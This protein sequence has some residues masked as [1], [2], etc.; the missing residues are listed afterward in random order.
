M[1]C[2]INYKGNIYSK[3]EFL[4]HMRENP[5]EFVPLVD[6]SM[7][8][9]INTTK[10]TP[11]QEKLEDEFS[12]DLVN[13]F[14]GV[15]ASAPVEVT[16]FIQNKHGFTPGTKEFSFM[17]RRE[18]L[19][20][21][22]SKEQTPFNNFVKRGI[23]SAVGTQRFEDL[24]TFERAMYDAVT[25]TVNILNKVPNHNPETQTV[26][27][28]SNGNYEVVENTDLLNKIRGTKGNEYLAID[29]KL[30]DYIIETF[31]ASSAVNADLILSPADK[32]DAK[33]KLLG[34]LSKLGIS[35]TSLDNYIKNY[36]SVNGV[37]PSVE[38]LADIT[39]K[40]VA[41]S[42]TGSTLEN[43][44]E[45]VSH[46]LV[47]AYQNQ[48][49]IDSVLP[50]V[51]TTDEWAQHS[52]HYTELYSQQGLVGEQLQNKVRREVLGKVIAQSVAQQVVE[53]TVYER[54]LGI[55]NNFINR[56]KA[57]FSPSMNTQLTDLVDRISQGAFEEAKFNNTFSQDALDS[58]AFDI[59]YSAKASTVTTNLQNALYAMEKQME[60][61]RNEGTGRSVKMRINTLAQ[62]IQNGD[63]LQG[64]STYLDMT[65]SLLVDVKRKVNVAK[66]LEKKGQLKG[67]ILLGPQ[68]ASAHL[69]MTEGKAQLNSLRAELLKVDPATSSESQK[70]AIS[71]MV[72]KLDAFNRDIDT[73]GGEMKRLTLQKGEEL[74]ETLLE[75]QQL[76][77]TDKDWFR[78][79]L[80]EKIHDVSML[81]F[82][83]GNMMN[84]SN[85]ILLMVSKLINKMHSRV[86]SRD[87]KF[88][89]T[90]Y[91][92][93]ESL[94][95]LDKMDQLIQ[96]DKN[97]NKTN[98]FESV[99][100]HQTFEND[101][102]AEKVKLYNEALLQDPVFAEMK[103][104]TKEH[105][106]GREDYP[107]IYEFEDSVRESYEKQLDQWMEDN[108]EPP[109]NASFKKMREDMFDAIS[110]GITLATG[111]V[112]NT[113]P[114]EAKQ[115]MADW[116]RR[117]REIKEPY[118][119]DGVVD[120]SAMSDTDR[121]ELESIKKERKMAAAII[122]ASTLSEKTGTELEI[123]LA[124][125]A[126]NV[127]YSSSKASTR[128]I[129]DVFIDTLNNYSSN[130]N[131][132]AGNTQALDFFFKNSG[133]S[134]NENFWND[135]ASNSESITEKIDNFIADN[136][137]ISEEAEMRDVANKL[138][139]ALKTRSSFL[140]QYSNPL[141]PAEV[142]VNSMSGDML[143][144]FRD[145]ESD[146]E[147][148]QQFLN[149]KL[150]ANSAVRVLEVESTA[151]EA[152]EEALANARLLR[153]KMSEVEFA[154]EHMTPGNKS[155]VILFQ[156]QL[157]SYNRNKI[158]PITGNFKYVAANL[159]GLPD[160][161]SPAEIAIAIEDYQI[162]PNNP[163]L[164][165]LYAKSKMVGYFKR[166]APKGFGEFLD[167]LKSGDLTDSNGN[168]LAFGDLIQ[169]IQ[170]GV[171]YTFTGAAGNAISISR[172]LSVNAEVEWLEDPNKVTANPKY[173][174]YGTNRVSHVG[175][176][177]PRVDKYKNQ[178]F[179]NK[180]KIDEDAYFQT[181]RLQSTS[182]SQSDLNKIE[183]L[184]LIVEARHEA[185]RNQ[186]LHETENAYKR[187]QVRKAHLE[188][189]SDIAS[190]N[191]VKN[192]TIGVKDAW[193]N[194]VDKMMYGE[195]L[196]GEMALDSSDIHNLKVP[197]LNVQNL[198]DLNE[199]TD[200]ILF[201]MTTHM[202]NAHLYNERMS[203]ANRIDQL[204]HLMLAKQKIRG[205]QVENSH[206]YKWLQD[207]KKMNIYG[208]SELQKVEIPLFNKKFNLTNALRA[209][210]SYQGMVN[211]GFNPAVAITSGT[212][213]MIFSITEAIMGEYIPTK[214]YKWAAGKFASKQP[215]FLSETGSVDKQNEIYVLGEKFGLFHLTERVNG[216][217][218]NKTLRTLYRE[219]INGSAHLMTEMLTHPYAPTAMYGV[220][221]DLRY[222]PVVNSSGISEMKLINFNE[223]SRINATTFATKKEMEQSWD[224]HVGNSIANNVTTENGEVTY[225]DNLKQILDTRFQGD[226]K[227]IEEEILHM[228][229]AISSGTENLVSKVDAKMPQY[230]KST[231]SRNAL[232][233]FALRHREW[234]TIGTQNRWKS[235][236]YNANTRQYEEGSYIT[237]SKY[238]FDSY[239]AF[240]FKDRNFK[241]FKEQFDLLDKTQKTNMKRVLIDSA[242]ST[243]LITLGALLV[244]PMVDDDENKENWAIQFAGYM[245][246]RLSSEQMT[247]GISGIPQT[248]DVIEA[249]FVAVNSMK[250]LLKPSNYS[251]DEV[252]GGVYDGHSKFYRLI[253]KQ[254]FVR[255]YYDT[256]YGISQKSDFFRLN[257]EW[258][259]WGMSKTSKVEKEE[260][261]AYEKDLFNT[262]QG[263]DRAG[264]R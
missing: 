256:R 42:E 81:M 224:L 101:R 236:H 76:E 141:N 33:K 168:S 60:I 10:Y 63:L 227:K 176:I 199:L 104:I 175:K 7:V 226:A 107:K 139:Q 75:E 178:D 158:M 2:E 171:D 166:F 229:N 71:R 58:S 11:I 208:V 105:Q 238:L 156:S 56:V 5:G 23:V 248:K 201:A 61:L 15:E 246:F 30:E 4:N 64:V 133:F 191:A 254:T 88:F 109:Y 200:D 84:T 245:Y 154:M 110:N 144:S 46:F 232:L 44:S 122:N 240:S 186:G 114:D 235:R 22:Y 99:I 95:M 131:L 26:L 106:I 219:G 51:E 259:L 173:V 108:T 181:G 205:K 18:G 129:K 234:F 262:F 16:D 134:F 53:G 264:M 161:S 237:M 151:N 48:S 39:N 6:S 182:G 85:P 189:V 119:N 167:K 102:E 203:V 38:A 228:E 24:T 25:D 243:I 69:L 172:Y 253:A 90:F 157:E 190:K 111:E 257:N 12:S 37:D 94:G 27:V 93:M 170:N 247:S 54:A 103:P 3:D 185:L 223:F 212:S 187:P 184:N 174:K 231:A 194:T 70:L 239:K 59:F 79:Q 112:V 263:P 52:A 67:P 159:L 250:E 210:D 96:V 152:F 128:T 241:A 55:V 130:G 66:E 9:E 215:S 222:V 40:V 218:F 255:H 135:I 147:N 65:N 146:I 117:R 198:E 126:M 1:T 31:N 145:L 35:T 260:A 202:H 138:T 225:S 118:M 163:S 124:F 80:N 91:K 162:N 217:Q 261:E 97:G 34:I 197:V 258:S 62:H 50:L 204:E 121:L 216:S 155:K 47:E 120:Y 195:T 164:H 230:D 113:V 19:R 125:Q 206:V 116:A 68:A 87:S 214:S 179:I 8:S 17:F 20:A 142:D 78:K 127:Y 150:P 86:R 220:M 149:K 213:G 89:N 45:E 233:R 77:E 74:F 148:Y 41:L 143:T 192:V 43:L 244:S 21:V 115:M 193:A 207:Y 29:Q 221:H 209:F 165:S 153:P 137:G 169:N 73:V 14:E 252:E 72:G 183:A 160:G 98:F 140:K 83:F 180:Y 92:K 251:S 49:E 123:A 32:N 100:D 242:I 136:P 132:I 28:N 177:Q 36:A 57:F 188:R 211:V 249:P 82:K 13:I 196:T